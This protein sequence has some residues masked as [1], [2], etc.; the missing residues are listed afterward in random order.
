LFTIGFTKKSAEQ[1]FTKLQRAGVA[2][3]LDVRLN[4]RSQLAG[5]AKKDDLK[6]FLKAI[7]GID[8][9]PLPELAPTKD[10]LD[11]HKKERGAWSVYQ[12]HGS[13]HRGPRRTRT[14]QN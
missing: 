4:N 2:R 14:P 8:Y 13:N 3:V 12:S 7:G 11:P 5:F 6:Y 9:V 10:T 1:F